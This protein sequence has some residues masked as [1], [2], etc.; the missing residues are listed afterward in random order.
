MIQQIRRTDIL[1]IID[2]KYKYFNKKFQHSIN[3]FF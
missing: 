3:F 2:F 1:A